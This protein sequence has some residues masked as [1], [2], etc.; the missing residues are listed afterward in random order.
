LGVAPDEV[1]FGHVVA[2]ECQRLGV[3]MA[4][5]VSGYDV[6]AAA[7]FDGVDALVSSLDRWA[8]CS[9]KV[10]SLG[11]AELDRLGWSPEV[12]LFAEDFGGGPKRLAPLLEALG[13]PEGVVFVGDTDHDR[14]CAAAA[15]VGFAL[16]AWNPRA[17]A[18]AQPGDVVLSKPADL[19]PLLR[20]G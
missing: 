3:S 13:E 12:A 2:D 15:G 18:L 17:A 11:V 14:A 1:T 5:Y 4:A 9:N 19:L 20:Q 16:A 6:G 10:R 8:V 7:P